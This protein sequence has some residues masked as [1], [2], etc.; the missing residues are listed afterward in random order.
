MKKYILPVYDPALIE[1]MVAIA[2]SQNGLVEIPKN[3]NKGAHVEAYQKAAHIRVGID[4]YCTAGIVWSFKEAV[5]K[6]FLNRDK[7]MPIPLQGS[8]NRC[9][10]YAIANKIEVEELTFIKRGDLLVYKNPFNYNGH[11]M[12]AT[13]DTLLEDFKKTPTFE[14]NT[15]S[16]NKADQR[17]GGGNFFKTRNLIGLIGKMKFRGVVGFKYVPIN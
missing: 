12:I 11:I 14:F 6:L 17:E 9:L 10:D 15:S 5:E 16:D 7:F 1:T 8:A 3:S 13:K 2:E 4:P